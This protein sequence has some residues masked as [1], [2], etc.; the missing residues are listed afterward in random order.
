M[1][2]SPIVHR[3]YRRYYLYAGSHVPPTHLSVSASNSTAGPWRYVQVVLLVFPPRC[4]L[5]AVLALF[6]HSHEV[7][8]T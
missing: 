3:A 6:L 8:G 2:I 7:G 5:A 4:P 1:I